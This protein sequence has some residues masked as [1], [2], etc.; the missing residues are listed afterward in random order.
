MVTIVQNPE[1]TF[2]FTNGEGFDIEL[3]F[4]TVDENGD[5]TSFQT[6]AIVDTESATVALADGTYVVTETNT[7][8]SSVVN[9]YKIFVYTEIEKCFLSSIKNALKLNSGD[10]E[11]DP[12]VSDTANAVA[13]NKMNRFNTLYY[14]YLSYVNKHV[15]DNW[16]F[17]S[18]DVEELKDLYLLET[19][20]AKLTKCC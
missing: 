3:A 16:A 5:L 10:C 7:G 11:D 8:T 4:Q 6:E 2:T 1:G 13:L 19:V 14:I 15:Y 17:T 20:R 18:I 12:C 9:N